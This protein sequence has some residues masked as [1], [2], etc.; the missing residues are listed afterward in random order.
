M[1]VGFVQIVVALAL[2]EVGKFISFYGYTWKL[3]CS[4]RIFHHVLVLLLRYTCE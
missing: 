2:I 3:S 1:F 4:F